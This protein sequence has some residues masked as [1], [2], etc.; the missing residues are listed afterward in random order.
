MAPGQKCCNWQRIARMAR[1][2]EAVALFR[3]ESKEHW[4]QQSPMDA[5]VAQQQAGQILWLG[6]IVRHKS[7]MGFH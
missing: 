7:K 2:L 1:Y 6:S 5:V 3:P 4:H